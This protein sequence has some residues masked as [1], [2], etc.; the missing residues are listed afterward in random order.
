LAFLRSNGTDPSRS[1]FRI[2]TRS[3]P[4]GDQQA[5]QARRVPTGIDLVTQ[6]HVEE[7]V[8]RLVA[9]FGD[10][11]EHGRIE[12]LMADSLAQ[13]AEPAQIPDFLPVLAYRFTRERLGSIARTPGIGSDVVFVS[14]SGGGRGQMAAALTTLLSDGKV[15][16][17]AAGA[18]RHGVL[19]PTVDR[20]IA[21]LG[22]DTSEF[23]VRPV[24]SDILAA[25]DVIVTMGHSVGEVKLPEGAR[26]QDWRVGDPIGASLQ[27]VRRVRDDIER[28]VQA[29]LVELRVLPAAEPGDEHEATPPRDS[30][31]E[32]ER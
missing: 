16:A 31:E 9:E 12:E 3:P 13:L 18:S 28:R 24:S 21:E 19:D 11:F 8:D 27:E 23:Y 26:Y 7:M 5:E 15:T 1:V 29:L 20:V 10:R 2:D 4:L 14:L 25:A 30:A 17:H 22:V 6:H 32:V